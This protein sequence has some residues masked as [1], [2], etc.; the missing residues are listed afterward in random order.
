MN[1]LPDSEI[2]AD[3]LSKSL[4]FF[5][6]DD[7]ELFHLIHNRFIKSQVSDAEI[8]SFLDPRVALKEITNSLNNPNPKPTLLLLDLNMPYLTGW[9]WLAEFTKMVGTPPDWLKI[10]ILSSSDSHQDRA[11]ARNY[12]FI[13][14]YLIK[15]LTK[16]TI[17]KM[18]K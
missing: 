14:D 5:L 9:E 11:Q 16:E 6:V 15:P 17:L 3:S 8:I 12:S 10:F 2:Q 18:Q 13:N 4:R 1:S 7:D